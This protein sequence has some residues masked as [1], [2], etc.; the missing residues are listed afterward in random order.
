M[1]RVRSS[2]RREEERV[3]LVSSGRRVE[4]GNLLAPAEHR[5]LAVT[6]AGLLADSDGRNR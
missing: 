5:K 2:E 6:L 1:A 4:V 3:M